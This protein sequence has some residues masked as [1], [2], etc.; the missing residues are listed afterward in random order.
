MGLKRASD[1]SFIVTP[2]DCVIHSD[3]LLYGLVV[4]FNELFSRFKKK[5][6]LVAGKQH[7]HKSDPFFENF[8]T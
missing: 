1:R 2:I 7:R 3:D 8:R 5:V 4:L 6:Y